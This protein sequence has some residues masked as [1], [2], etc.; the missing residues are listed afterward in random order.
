MHLLFFKC[1]SEAVPL[2]RNNENMLADS[3]S[4]VKIIN[5]SLGKFVLDI[6]AAI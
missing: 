5:L 1:I 6:N 2:Q 3:G 4:R